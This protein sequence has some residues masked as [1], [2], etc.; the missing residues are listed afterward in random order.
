MNIITNEKFSNEDKKRIC[1]EVE[2]LVNNGNKKGEAKK[3]VAEK[4]GIKTSRI[5]NWIYNSDSISQQDRQEKNNAICQEVLNYINNGYGQT[6]AIAIVSIKEDKNPQTLYA[7][8]KSYIKAN[9]KLKTDA[10]D[11]IKEAICLEVKTLIDKGIKV[12][13][14]MKKIALKYG[15]DAIEIAIWDYKYRKFSSKFEEIIFGK[16]LIGDEK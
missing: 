3:I 9:P 14:A 15:I 13:D 7:L 10:T 8:Y 12:I 5:T 1:K 6:K 2:N 16:T 11:E 4:Y